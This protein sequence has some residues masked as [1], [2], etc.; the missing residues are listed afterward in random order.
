MNEH[1]LRKQIEEVEKLT[2]DEID[3]VLEHFQKKSFYRD[4]N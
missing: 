1:P 2:D 3:F 4:G